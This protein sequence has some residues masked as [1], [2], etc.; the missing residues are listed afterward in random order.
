MSVTIIEEL[1]AKRKGQLDEQRAIVAVAEKA[2]RDLTTEESSEFD[3]R[4]GEFDSLSGRIERLEKLEGFVADNAPENPAKR[5]SAPADVDPEEL[6][7]ER[8]RAFESFIRS[9]GRP[10]RMP[11][12]QRAAMQVNTDSEG[13]YTVP[14]EFHRN[15]I[16]AEREFGTIR[17]HATVITSSDNGS[18]TIPGTDTR[19]TAAWTAE[20]ADY[21]ESES[22]FKA[23]VLT[24]H[25]VGALSKVS[26][27]LLEDSEFDILGFLATDLGEAIGIKENTAYCIGA[28]NSTTSPKGIFTL[29]GTGFTGA[30]NATP[31]VTSDDLI[32]TY[33][34][35]GV[36]YRARASWVFRDATAKAIRKL[37]D[38]DN[39]YLWQPGLQAGMP[40]TIL[41]RPVVIDPDAPAIAASAKS[42]AFGDLKAYWIRDITG[43]SVKVLNELYAVSGQV[44][45]RVSRRTDGAIADT[46]AIK[47]FAHGA[48][49]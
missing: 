12:E 2:G 46:A 19:A 14:D 38:G 34:G 8:T 26:D 25:K 27:E 11:Q 21:T 5:D 30:V 18:L 24:G 48:A 32:E 15:L 23:T 10:D 1:R 28:S 4:Q 16:V 13:G 17:Q 45:F 20:E 9:G 3:K 37:K 33:H 49:S 22:T 36:P 29:A 44:G 42:I 31:G 6:A 40:D 7:E 47:V 43:T 39:Q 41:G 35:L